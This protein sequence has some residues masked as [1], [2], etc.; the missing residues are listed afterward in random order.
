MRIPLSVIVLALVAVAGCSNKG[1]RD[2]RAPGTG[3]DEFMILPAKPLTQPADYAVLPPP[4][5]GGSNITD[6]HPDADAVAALGGRPE[7]L[8]ATGIPASD[9]ALVTAASRNGVEPGVRASLASQD[10]EF[11]KRQ[12]RMTRFRLFPVDR[13]SQ[14]YRK[15]AL[16]PFR[17][18]QE[19]RNRGFGTPTSPPAKP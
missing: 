15:Q 17:Q 6:Q 8:N 7:A 10:A 5:P 1:L 4:T 9:G 11:R 14:A 13:Y 19:F 2:L 16:D 18:T 3:P 12:S